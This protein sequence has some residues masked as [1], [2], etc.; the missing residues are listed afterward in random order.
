MIRAAFLLLVIAPV[1]YSQSDKSKFSDNYGKAAFLALKAIERDGSTDGLKETSVTIDSA[2]AEAQ[3]DAEK[4]MTKALN[5]ILIDHVI[6]N[7]ELRN[8]EMQ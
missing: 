3:T 6:N 2:D 7:A 8:L 5:H 1:A 4:D